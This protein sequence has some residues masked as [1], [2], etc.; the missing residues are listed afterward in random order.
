MPSGPYTELARWRAVSRR[1]GEI[2]DSWARKHPIVLGKYQGWLVSIAA[3]MIA[4]D[5]DRMEKLLG[6]PP[7]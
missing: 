7:G 4:C 6:S 1:T 2:L 3:A 5:L